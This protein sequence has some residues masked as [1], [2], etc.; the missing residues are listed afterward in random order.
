[1]KSV[2]GSCLYEMMWV[3]DNFSYE[4][5]W[6][7]GGS[8]SYEMKSIRCNCSYEMSGLVAVACNK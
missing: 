5:K 1:M 6:V 2:N 3:T 4:I 8:W 7:S